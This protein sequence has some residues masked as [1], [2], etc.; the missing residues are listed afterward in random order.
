MCIPITHDLGSLAQCKM[1]LVCL[2]VF[3]GLHRVNTHYN[4][5]TILLLSMY[6]KDLKQDTTE[7]LADPCSMQHYFQ[8]QIMESV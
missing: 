8:C 4:D 6:L 3:L 7:I 1:F 5:L 2:H